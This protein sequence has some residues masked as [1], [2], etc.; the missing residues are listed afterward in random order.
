MGEE[1]HGYTMSKEPRTLLS[2]ELEPQA[3][4]TLPHP[5][6]SYK[7]QRSSLLVHK[8]KDLSATSQSLSKQT[9][10]QLL[11]PIARRPKPQDR[12]EP[13]G[14]NMSI[15]ISLWKRRR[16]GFRL[17]FVPRRRSQKKWM[18]EPGLGV[19][20]VMEL[21]CLRLPETPFAEVTTF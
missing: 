19:A 4:G 14:D 21:Y 9:F 1:Q 11:F 12:T 13:R 8:P 16:R 2:G 18:R 15:K 20:F 5:A 10:S 17:T 7:E 6:R 3:G